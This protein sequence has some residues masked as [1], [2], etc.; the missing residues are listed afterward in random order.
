[1]ALRRYPVVVVRSVGVS[2]TVP[3]VGMDFPVDDETSPALELLTQ[4]TQPELALVP[5][6]AVLP[7]VEVTVSLERAD[8]KVSVLL[9]RLKENIGET[10]P[11]TPIWSFTRM[12]R[13][14]WEKLR[15]VREA[16]A[17]VRDPTWLFPTDPVVRVL[18]PAKSKQ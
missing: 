18:V 4:A 12:E 15:V 9:S 17:R 1:M 6:V 8:T 11:L 3:V 13:A 7:P 2:L 14:Y 5:I 10:T 16:S